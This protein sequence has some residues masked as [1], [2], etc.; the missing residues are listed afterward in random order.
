[1]RAPGH[2]AVRSAAKLSFQNAV[3]FQNALR[4]AVPNYHLAVDH[5]LKF[6]FKG[7]AKGG[8]LFSICFTAWNLQTNTPAISLQSPSS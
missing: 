3:V 4:A 8:R 7:R 1:M 2:A 6:A 5:H